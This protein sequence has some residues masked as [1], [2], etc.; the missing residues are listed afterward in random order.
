MHRDALR[1]QEETAIEEKQLPDGNRR[2]LGSEVIGGVF[3][4]P[5]TYEKITMPPLT[6]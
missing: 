6:K 4:I 5:E 3:E 1:S 2:F